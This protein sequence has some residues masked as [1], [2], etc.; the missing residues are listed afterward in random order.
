MNDISAELGTDATGD[1]IRLFHMLPQLLTLSIIFFT[2][3]AKF[4]KA[5]KVVQNCELNKCCSN[6]AKKEF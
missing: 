6:Q 5:F 3:F 4:L 2:I 1:L